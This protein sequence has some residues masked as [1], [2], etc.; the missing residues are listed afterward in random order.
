MSGAY[1][2]GALAV[3]ERVG[4]RDLAEHV[5]RSIGTGVRDVAAAFLGLQPHLVVGAAD[6][7]GRVWASCSPVH[8]VSY[9][10]PGRTG[11]RSPAGHRREIRSPGR[12]PRP[13]PGSGPSRS[14]RAPG[15]GCG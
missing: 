5:G 1:H 13:G 4:V 15:A 2:W 3:Q 9:G 8:P 10:P 12:W 14:T 6:G 11:S 7:A